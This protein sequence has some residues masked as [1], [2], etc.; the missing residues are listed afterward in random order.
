MLLFQLRCYGIKPEFAIEP[1]TLSFDHILLFSHATHFLNFTN[2]STVNLHW[3]F[4]NH[5]NFS[6]HFEFSK[7]ENEIAPQETQVIHIGYKSHTEHVIKNMPLNI[8]VRVLHS[9]LNSYLL[10]NF[11]D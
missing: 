6:E 10:P 1:K 8:E 3:R 4:E 5:Q 9:V 11:N 2:K 7:R